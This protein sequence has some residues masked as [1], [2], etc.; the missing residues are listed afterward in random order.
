[1]SSQLSSVGG[2][3]S[4]SLKMMQ[5]PPAKIGLLLLLWGHC[6]SYRDMW[7]SSQILVLLEFLCDVLIQLG[8]RK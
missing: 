4:H 8:M 5:V 7:E 2:K 1:M 3:L 6:F